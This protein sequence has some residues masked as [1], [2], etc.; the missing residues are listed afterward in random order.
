MKTEG[1]PPSSFALFSFPLKSQVT[2]FGDPFFIGVKHSGQSIWTVASFGDGSHKNVVLETVSFSLA[3]S[4][5]GLS[6]RQLAQGPGSARPRGFF[7]RPHAQA[8]DFGQRA[9]GTEASSCTLLFLLWESPG[10][11]PLCCRDPKR[12]AD[13]KL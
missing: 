7:P 4:C 13:F 2:H 6:A 12:W 9:P 1:W 3:F 11:P 8:L 10:L 5:E